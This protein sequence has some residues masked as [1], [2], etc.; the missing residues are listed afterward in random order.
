MNWLDET[1][2]S[3]GSGR[4]FIDVPWGDRQAFLGVAGLVLVSV[5]A[6]AVLVVLAGLASNGTND[7]SGSEPLWTIL[8][9]TCV[10]QVGMV[11][12]AYRLGPYGRGDPVLL[13]GVRTLERPTLLKWAFVGFFVSAT[14]SVIYVTVAELISSDLVPPPVPEA[15]DVNELRV[16]TFASIVIMAPMAEEVFFRG[17]LF[18]GL[19]RR[20][21]P[22]GA[23]AI[24]GAVFAATHF[25]VALLGPA[26]I[27]GSVFAFLYWRTGSIWPGIVTHTAQNGIAFALAT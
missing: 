19:L 16:L 15:I 24:S 11:T 20:F 12:V 27:G 25:D 1:G 8:A 9:A 26:F 7:T 10:L 6:T 13:T 23:A 17:F 5:V 21:G 22:I 2:G 18:A 4:P 14:L 3:P